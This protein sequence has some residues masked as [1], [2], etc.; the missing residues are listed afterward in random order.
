MSTIENNVV[1]TNQVAEVA[2]VKLH[3]EGMQ[4]KQGMQGYLVYYR[5]DS[6]TKTKKPSKFVELP[7]ITNAELEQNISKLLPM[8]GK[9]VDDKRLE[10]LRELVD[11]GA[12]QVNIADYSLNKVIEY[13]N[14]VATGARFSKAMVEAWFN[15]VVAEK[16][17]QA[18][19]AKNPNLTENE[20][21]ESVKNNRELVLP[22]T[23]L[24][25]SENIKWAQ[26]TID[27]VKR[28]LGLVAGD[29]IAT[30]LNNI[31]ATLIPFDHNKYF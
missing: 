31:V 29:D 14:S 23:G 16:L 3:A 15:D 28:I 25:A 26:V 6:K 11:T 4:A 9:L 19:L 8:L 12:S 21:A 30:R 20:I 2:E 22:L 24:K 17:I 10:L 18:M 13:S 27:H 5:T 7:I 1:N